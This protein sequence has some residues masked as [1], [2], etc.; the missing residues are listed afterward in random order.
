MLQD[1]DSRSAVRWGWDPG[2][3]SDAN[4]WQQRAVRY[5]RINSQTETT[6]AIGAMT[7]LTHGGTV[8]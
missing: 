4:A 6:P 3:C 2:H 5:A 7:W 8:V 1:S